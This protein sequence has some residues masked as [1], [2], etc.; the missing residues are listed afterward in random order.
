MKYDPLV[1]NYFSKCPDL[2]SDNLL[3]KSKFPIFKVFKKENDTLKLIDVTYI[4]EIEFAKTLLSI[5]NE[6][7]SS[8]RLTITDAPFV[9][10][11]KTKKLNTYCKEVSKL[12]D[13]YLHLKFFNIT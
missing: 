2:E 11:N 1:F 12:L 6:E 9:K 10:I 5:W 4:K 8:I 7:N 13:E 3:I